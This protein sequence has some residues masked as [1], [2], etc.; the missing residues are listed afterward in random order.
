MIKS[1]TKAAL[2]AWLKRETESAHESLMEDM[3]F[4]VAQ[5]WEI[6]NDD[7]ELKELPL[8]INHESKIVQL[9]A[10]QCLKGKSI[11]DTDLQEELTKI[12]VEQFDECGEK[13]DMGYNH[14]RLYQCAKLY[15]EL[16]EKELADQWKSWAWFSPYE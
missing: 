4:Y 7:T 9:L 15:E 3:S 12:L 13:L 1:V 6:V 8:L 16:G 11:Y 10:K 2:L 14:G 5:D